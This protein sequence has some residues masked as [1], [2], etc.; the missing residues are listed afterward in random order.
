MVIEREQCEFQPVAYAQLIEDIG[1]VALH[2]LLAYPERSCD[3]LIRTPFGDEGDNLDLAAGEAVGS[4]RRRRGLRGELPQYLDQVLHRPAI[5]PVLALHDGANT[6]GQML[7]CGVFEHN[8]AGA[9]L[10]SFQNLLLLDL[11][12][13]EDGPGRRL[14]GGE[15]P[16]GFHPRHIRHGQV[17]QQ[18]L[19]LILLDQGQGFGAVACFGN[20]LEL[21]VGKQH[22]AQADP[23]DWMIVGD[24][25]SDWVCICHSSRCLSGRWDNLRPQPLLQFQLHEA[26]QIGEF[27]QL[28]TLRIELRRTASLLQ[29]DTELDDGR[30]A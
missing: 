29:L 12:R 6:R 27:L 20:H 23:Y 8:S 4:A 2:R 1:E 26:K 24:E 10:E 15:F 11:G 14:L 3:V 21:V 7:D 18:N 19:R 22:V 25:E 13:Q 17:E 5:Q 30:Y 28:S 16:Q 9:E